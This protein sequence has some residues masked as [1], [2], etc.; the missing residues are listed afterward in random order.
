[1]AREEPTMNAAEAARLLGICRQAIY[2]GWKRNSIP[3]INGE[4]PKSWVLKKIIKK[5]LHGSDKTRLYQYMLFLGYGRVHGQHS[6]I[7]SE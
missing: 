2:M 6:P 3:K 5:N 7:G 4:V 1:M